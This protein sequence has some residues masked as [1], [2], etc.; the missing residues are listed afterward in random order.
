MLEDDLLATEISLYVAGVEPLIL[1]RK[2]LAVYIVLCA[3]VDI[4]SYLVG[5]MPKAGIVFRYDPVVDGAIEVVLVL[6][7]LRV[8]NMETDLIQ[9]VGVVR[10]PK[11]LLSLDRLLVGLAPI[12]GYSHINP[13]YALCVK[14][15]VS[16]ILG[17]VPSEGRGMKMQSYLYTFI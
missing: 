7:M 4:K 8:V 10:G 1:D 12:P 11:S 6:V 16:D 17:E 2:V 9:G 14:A 15:L 3:R 13:C 5:G